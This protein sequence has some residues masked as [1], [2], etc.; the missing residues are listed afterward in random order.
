MHVIDVAVA[1]ITSDRKACRNVITELA[2]QAGVDP[3]AAIG[4]DTDLDVR[5]ELVARALAADIDQAGQ[6]RRAE[7]RTLRA[8]QYFDLIDVEQHS[9]I[10]RAGEID[11]IDRNPY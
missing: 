3:G 2:A 6:C 10:R 4:A 8:S 5:G 11:R 7:A 1:F 9:G